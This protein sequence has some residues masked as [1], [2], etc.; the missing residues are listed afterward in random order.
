MDMCFASAAKEFR[1]QM[2]GGPEAASLP[3]PDGRGV[4]KWE[5]VAEAFKQIVGDIEGAMRKAEGAHQGK[6][7][8]EA[9]ASIAEVMPKAE[10][11]SE[12]SRG[13]RDS[14][15]QQT[16]NQHEAFQNIPAQGDTLENGREVQ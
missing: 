5:K 13:I 14:L 7:A 15:Q 6:A 10:K 4:E 12:T 2:G 9:N 3:Q 16:Q 8:E 11:V 1:N